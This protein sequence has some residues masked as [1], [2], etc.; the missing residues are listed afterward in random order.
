MKMKKVEC[1][2]CGKRI[3]MDFD[4]LFD[5]VG[6]YMDGIHH[7]LCPKCKKKMNH[8]NKQWIKAA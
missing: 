4:A 5:M 6:G 1:D 2:K 3:P 7:D 8:M